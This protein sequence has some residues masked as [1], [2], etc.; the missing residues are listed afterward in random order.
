MQDAITKDQSA[1]IELQARAQ[2]FCGSSDVLKDFLKAHRA[3]LVRLAAE[4]STN[5]ALH[6]SALINLQSAAATGAILNKLYGDD[7]WL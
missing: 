6:Q 7:S 2:S 3:N 4:Q 5:P 1:A